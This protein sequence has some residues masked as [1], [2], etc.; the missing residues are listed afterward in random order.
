MTLW[1]QVGTTLASMWTT[2]GCRII[3]II[4]I[5]IGRMLGVP[6][7]GVIS[8]NKING[9]TKMKLL[10]NK[11]QSPHSRSRHRVHQLPPCPSLPVPSN[12][13]SIHSCSMILCVSLRVRRPSSVLVRWFACISFCCF[14]THVCSFLSFPL[15][16]R[17]SYHCWLST[18]TTWKCKRSR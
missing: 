10:G 16:H 13:S 1:C 2:F 11:S 18:Y 8:Q 12:S 4:I 17:W 15:T 6:C 9:K 5:N 7:I 3:I 14:V